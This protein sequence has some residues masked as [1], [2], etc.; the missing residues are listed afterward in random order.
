MKHE[1]KKWWHD[2][3]ILKDRFVNDIIKIKES[4]GKIYD[5][6]TNGM[7]RVY[8]LNGNLRYE[9]EYKDG[10]RADGKSIGW[11]PNGKIKIIRNWVNG[12]HKGLQQEFYT[13]GKIW[14]EEM[15]TDDKDYGEFVEYDQ[16]GKKMN[17]GRF[18]LEYLVDRDYGVK[19]SQPYWDENEGF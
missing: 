4:P 7:F 11:W 12:T 18:R 1:D 14:L 19:V 5:T 15:I 13:N 6:P 9:W 17:E 2:H 3:P 10:E 16:D 8:W